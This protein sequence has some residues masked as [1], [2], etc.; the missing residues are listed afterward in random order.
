MPLILLCPPPQNRDLSLLARATI[1]WGK[2]VPRQLAVL[3]C[4]LKHDRITPPTTMAREK[5]ANRVTSC[6]GSCKQPIILRLWLRNDTCVFRGNK[7]VIKQTCCWDLRHSSMSLDS[8]A[9]LNN[10]RVIYL[11]MWPL[12]RGVL[13]YACRP[14]DMRSGFLEGWLLMNISAPE[15]QLMQSQLRF[16]SNDCSQY[17]CCCW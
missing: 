6:N 16:C 8:S 17:C 9:V 4:T 1:K 13:W 15:P 10:Y 12:F 14:T 7:P 5:T 3:C 11:Y 2:H